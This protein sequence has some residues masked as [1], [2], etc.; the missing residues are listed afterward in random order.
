MSGHKVLAITTNDKLQEILHFGLTLEFGHEVISAPYDII[1]GAYMEQF[2]GDLLYIIYDVANTQNTD[3]FLKEMS[4]HIKVPL[5][6]VM[7]IEKVPFNRNL[8]KR[9]PYCYQVQG[10]KLLDKLGQIIEENFERQTQNQAIEFLPVLMRTFLRFP[11]LSEDVFIQLKSGRYLRL[12]QK[13]D[14]VYHEDVERY[15]DKG[16]DYLF[17]ARVRAHWLLKTIKTHTEDIL[18]GEGNN[19][20]NVEEAGQKNLMDTMSGKEIVDLFGNPANI[21]NMEREFLKQ[22]E[23]RSR[24]TKELIMVNP[25]LAKTFKNLKVDRS[26]DAFFLARA[27]LVAAISCGLAKK[28]DW[29]SE[30]NMDKLIYC[31]YVHDVG[32]ANNLPLAHVLT[33]SD[34]F[35]I[36]EKFPPEAKNRL[37]EHPEMA[38]KLIAKHMNA[39]PDCEE[40]VRQHHELPNGDGFPKKLHSARIGALSAILIVSIDLAQYILLK[41]KWSP[42]GFINRRREKYKG[43]NFYK[44]LNVL[45][46]IPFKPIA[47]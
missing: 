43:G 34:Y 14:A 4:A 36:K 2:A 26:E 32:L 17:L 41:P 37:I 31:S 40:I 18:R 30:G 21:L 39:P 8:T 46:N 10:E 3:H 7:G 12:Y 35:V 22:V 16:V 45:K 42:S 27:E 47:P 38:A 20:D 28:M 33:M 19:L 25:S 13:G 5:F 11:A 44:I 29:G 6:L 1:N 15:K 23:V 9:V 24:K